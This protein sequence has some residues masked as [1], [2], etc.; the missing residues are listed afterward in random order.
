MRL[1]LV[2]WFFRKSFLPLSLTPVSQSLIAGAQMVETESTPEC[3]RLVF[4]HMTC[5]LPHSAYK[6]KY[7]Y[8]II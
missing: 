4:M 1:C 6:N 7:K 3:Y 8:T 5:L 2:R